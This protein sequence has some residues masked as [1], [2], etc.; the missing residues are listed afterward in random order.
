MTLITVV[1]GIS[2][3]LC[4]SLVNTEFVDSDVHLWGKALQGDTALLWMKNHHML[5]VLVSIPCLDAAL[6]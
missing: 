2:F 4:V 5:G 1:S 6:A 3:C